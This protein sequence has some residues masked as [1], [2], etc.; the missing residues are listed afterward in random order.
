MSKTEI[1]AVMLSCATATIKL[2]VVD[3]RVLGDF[4]SVIQA[5]A[6]CVSA[7]AHTS[8]TR[9][10]SSSPGEGENGSSWA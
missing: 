7:A 5:I 2:S 4:C 9:D 10:C 8:I 6:V 1:A 3:C